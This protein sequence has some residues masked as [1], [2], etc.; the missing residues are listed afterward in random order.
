[1]KRVVAIDGPSGAGKS[2]VAKLISKEMGFEYLDTGALYRAV[3]LQ[4]LRFGVREDASDK[5]I[6]DALTRIHVEFSKGAVL[7]NREEVSDEIRSNE[8]SHYASVFSAKEPVRRY[9]LDI[10]RDAALHGDLVAEGRDMT[11][12]VFPDAYRKFYLDASAEERARRRTLELNSM[13]VA[14]DE[15]QVRM[16]ITERDTRDSRRDIAPLRK[17]ADAYV[18]DSSGIPVEEVFR[19]MMGV[20]R[21]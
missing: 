9:L 10:Q 11:T 4:L 13:G 2:T 16:D 6:A 20:I 7:L 5:D 1:M 14:V 21:S 15:E 18:L 8:V 19:K 17:A 3:A 12:V